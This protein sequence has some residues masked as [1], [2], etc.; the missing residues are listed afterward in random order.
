MTKIKKLVFISILTALSASLT[1]FQF[2][3]GRGYVHFG[4]S[5][6]YITALL[7]GPLPAAFAGGVGHAMA[8]YISGYP[9]YILPTLVIK[10]LTGFTFGLIAGDGRSFVRLS[11][12]FMVAL[13]IITGGYFLA[14]I[15]IGNTAEALLSLIASPIQWLMSIAAV[16]AFLPVFRKIIKF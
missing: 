11:A 3:L 1:L 6:I 15:V 2:R 16:T 7:L 8:D 5:I 10:S 9:V 4:D 12:A 13:V 14:E